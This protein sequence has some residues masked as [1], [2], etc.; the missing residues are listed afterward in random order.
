MVRLKRKESI[1]ISRLD[2]FFEEFGVFMEEMMDD[3]AKQ[4][5]FE[6][7]E[8][9]KELCEEKMPSGGGSYKKRFRVDKRGRQDDEY[10]YLLRNL[11]LFASHVEHGTEPHKITATGQLSETDYAIRSGWLTAKKIAKREGYFDDRGRQARHGPHTSRTYKS[12]IAYPGGGGWT[13]GSHHPITGDVMVVTQFTM[14]GGNVVDRPPDQIAQTSGH[15][16]THM[17][18][19][20]GTGKLTDFTVPYGQRPEEARSRR[21]GAKSVA[22]YNANKDKPRSKGM[23]AEPTLAGGPYQGQ[24]APMGTKYGDKVLI[25]VK[26]NHPGA[27]AFN[28]LGETADKIRD[29]FWDIFEGVWQAKVI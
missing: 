25:G 5:A 13:A 2:E 19:Q 8:I 28:I 10:I 9:A 22:D 16:Y 17:L 14:P 12:R 7:V 27:R 24:P 29:G 6:G 18:H 21:T 3:I 1:D 23:K 26:F 20:R 11:H 4:M 15:E